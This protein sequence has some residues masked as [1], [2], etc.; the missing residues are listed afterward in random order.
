MAP[1]KSQPVDWEL[2]DVPLERINCV[3]ISLD[4]PTGHFDRLCTELALLLSTCS[5]FF[6]ALLSETLQNR[7]ANRIHGEV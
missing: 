2:P 5:K 1:K 4:V 7:S 3:R 6:C